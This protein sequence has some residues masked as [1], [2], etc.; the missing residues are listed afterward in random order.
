VH[1][2]FCPGGGFPAGFWLGDDDD[3]G[4]GDSDASAAGAGAGAG[5]VGSFSTARP[6]GAEVSGVVTVGAAADG[7]VTGAAV[8]GTGLV[9]DCAVGQSTT[10]SMTVMDPKPTNSV[11]TN[12]SGTKILRLPIRREKR[13]R[14]SLSA[15]VSA[16]SAVMSSCRC[17]APSTSGSAAG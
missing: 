1:Y 9:S 14:L 12:A 4:A 15:V 17:G 13:R 2:L 8:V 6:L 7:G 10:L 3:G 16:D 11:A 5:G